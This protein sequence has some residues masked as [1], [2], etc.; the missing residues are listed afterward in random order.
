M[1]AIK[2]MRLEKSSQGGCR[3]RVVANHG[4]MDVD[5]GA[6]E[7]V[8]LL[9]KLAIDAIGA[10]EALAPTDLSGVSMGGRYLTVAQLTE[11]HAYASLAPRVDPDALTR[12]FKEGRQLPQWGLVAEAEGDTGDRA[13]FATEAEAIEWAE[14]II[15]AGDWTNEEG[16]LDGR[17][18][19]CTYWLTRDGERMPRTYTVDVEA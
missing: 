12:A 13:R 15:R 3:V 8:G 1:E 11:A 9:G 17:T 16:K 6:D 14:G 2:D 4:T 19:T 10:G 5:L 18:I 7:I